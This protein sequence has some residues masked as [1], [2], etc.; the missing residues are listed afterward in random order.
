MVVERAGL[1]P[2]VLSGAVVVVVQAEGEA[3]PPAN[4]ERLALQGEDR[5]ARF[6]VPTAGHRAH[7]HG[8]SSGGNWRAP[9]VRRPSAL[10]VN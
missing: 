10:T 9:S 8:V 7:E 5:Q 2:G 4:E 6:H 3:E 1:D